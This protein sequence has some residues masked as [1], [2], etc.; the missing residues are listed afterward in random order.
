LLYT[1]RFED[2][3]ATCSDDDDPDDADL[4]IEEDS[5]PLKIITER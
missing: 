5:D 1:T 2:S 4:E 3:E